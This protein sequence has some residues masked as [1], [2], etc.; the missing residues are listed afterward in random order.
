MDPSG[1]HQFTCLPVQRV[2][3]DV[4]MHRAERIANFTILLAHPGMRW[5]HIKSFEEER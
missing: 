5:F 3:S 1:R 2:Q 4:A